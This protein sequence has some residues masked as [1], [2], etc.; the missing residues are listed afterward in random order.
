MIQKYY[1]NVLSNRKVIVLVS[2]YT[3]CS[4]VHLK[5]VKDFCVAHFA[6]GLYMCLL[7]ESVSEAH[8]G[9]TMATSTMIMGLK[10][11]SM[12]IILEG[13]W[14]NMS[15]FTAVAHKVSVNNGY[16]DYSTNLTTS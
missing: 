9:F 12:R 2:L 8:L 14:E 13:G 4:D 6:A 15:G 16:M 1:K 3:I 11:S 5:K 10:R 7:Q